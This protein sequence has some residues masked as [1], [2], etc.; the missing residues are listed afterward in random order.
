MNSVEV[1]APEGARLEEGLRRRCAAFVR[2]VLRR[3]NLQGWEVS[4]LLCDDRRIRELN[5][6]YR[7]LDRPTDVL[8]F[9]QREGAPTAAG[10]GGPSPA[11]DIVVSLQT[12]RRNAEAQGVEASEELKR[13]LIHGILHLEGLEH[14]EGQAEARGEASM[15]GLQERL[16]GELKRGRLL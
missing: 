6:K 15:I 11:G 13:L 7:G 16:L 5:R 12:L 14:P 3:R 1:G 8:S 10:G 9:S 2:R 4:V